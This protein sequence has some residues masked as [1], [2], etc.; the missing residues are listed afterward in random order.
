VG[1]QQIIGTIMGALVQTVGIRGATEQPHYQVVERVNQLEVRRYEGR[2]AAETVVTG[3][4]EQAR[5]NGFRLV[6]GYIFGGNATSA[7]VAM[8][9]PVAQVSRGQQIAMTAPV[10]QQASERGWRIQFFMPSKYTLQTLP[11]PKDER[12]RLVQMPPQTYAVIAFSGDRSPRAVALQQGRL[13]RALSASSWR[14][15][16]QPQ[17][18]FY[19]PPWTLPFLRRNEVAMQVERR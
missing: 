10:T 15:A 2:V 4:E 12:V 11:K 18:W 8:T 13:D 17:A 9:A 1:V 5:N 16:G 19:D 3:D 7:Q 14:P 6:A